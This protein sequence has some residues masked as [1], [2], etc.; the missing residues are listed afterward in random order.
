MEVMTL[1]TCAD[2]SAGLA[3]FGHGGV[4]RLRRLDSIRGHLGGFVGVAGDAL[5]GGSH[6]FGTGRDALQVLADLLRDL[7]NGVGLDGGLLGIGSNLLAGFEQL[8]AGGRHL[9]RYGR[10]PGAGFLA[11]CP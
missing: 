7:G 2:L 4:G 1:M 6:L 8:L 5:N 11:A 9:L 10:R 3:Q